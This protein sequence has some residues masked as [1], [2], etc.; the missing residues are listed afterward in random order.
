MIRLRA[1]RA[2]LVE[3]VAGLRRPRAEEPAGE[4]DGGEAEQE[5]GARESRELARARRRALVVSLLC[6]AAVIALFAL[7][8]PG[9]PWLVLGRS[10]EGAFT[11]GV[12]LVAAYAGFRLAQYLHLR[13]V[14][15]VHRELLERER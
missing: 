4:G 15:R 2:L 1:V 7:R 8:E 11:A 14:A 3:E 6:A 9:R 13:T 10:E 12:L 5:T